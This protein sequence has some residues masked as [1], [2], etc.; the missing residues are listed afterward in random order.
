MSEARKHAKNVVANWVGY[1][2]YMVT[3]FFLTPFLVR[4]L[5]D[6]RYGV[7]TLTISLV[8]YLGFVDMGV[9]LSTGRFINYYLGQDDAEKVNRVVNTSLAFFGIIGFVAVSGAAVLALGLERIFASVPEGLVEE[10]RAVL[11]ILSLIVFL[12]FFNNTFDQLLHARDRFDIRSAVDTFIFLA[13]AGAVVWVLVNGGGLIA[14][15]VVQ[16]GFAFFRC[17][18]VF[19]LARWKGPQVAFRWCAVSLSTFKEV[20]GF[21]VWAFIGAFG[22]RLIYCSNVVIIGLLLGARDVTLYAI[23]CMLIDSGRALVMALPLQVL[24]PTTERAA[25]RQSGADLR[26]LLVRGSQMAMFFAV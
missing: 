23:G 9:R 7:W 16:V 10:A 14:L 21:G 1:S 4:S 8:G 17:V 26:W 19:W 11:L 24:K 5:G 13:R 22:Y 25:G 15:A 3:A 18:V 2:A 12:E 20:F 6:V